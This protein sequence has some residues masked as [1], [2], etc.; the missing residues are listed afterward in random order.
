VAGRKAEAD[1]PGQ[2]GNGQAPV[3]LQF[4][5]RRVKAWLPILIDGSVPNA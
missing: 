4:T 3:L 2:F 5:N 1:A